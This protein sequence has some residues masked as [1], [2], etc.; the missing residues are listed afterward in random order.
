[1]ASMSGVSDSSLM[2]TSR[3]SYGLDDGGY[4]TDGVTVGVMFG[5]SDLILIFT[6]VFCS[7]FEVDVASDFGD[8]NV[9][10]KI[11]ECGIVI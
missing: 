7:T 6:L 1:M 9:G 8:V 4:A 5:F 3:V 10:L 11:F 2:F